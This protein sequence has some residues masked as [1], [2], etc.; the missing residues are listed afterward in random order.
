MAQLNDCKVIGNLVQNPELKRI[1]EGRAVLNFSIAVNEKRK[2]GDSVE[3]DVTFINVVAWNGMAENC[4][5][6]L[7]KGSPVLLQGKL[8]Q[9]GWDEDGTTRSKLYVVA[10]DVQFLSRKNGSADEKR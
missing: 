1:E 8:K 10:K 4:A 5:K 2:S 9:K 6:Y 7:K 3:E